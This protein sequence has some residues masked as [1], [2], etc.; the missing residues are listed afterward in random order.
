MKSIKEYIL[1]NKKSSYDLEE[2]IKKIY[3]DHKDIFDEKPKFDG[4]GTWDFRIINK[5]IMNN[6][7]KQWNKNSDL[8]KDLLN[9]HTKFEKI[10]NDLS[11]E[12]IVMYDNGK[13]SGAIYVYG[14]DRE[15]S[16]GFAIKI[17]RNINKIEVLEAGI[18]VLNE[19]IK[20]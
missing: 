17:I 10:P 16:L 15:H 14:M 2:E 11:K 1:E 5:E 9:D 18:K 6:I 3:N 8:I 4:W 7:K 12:G 19:L 13:P 20:K